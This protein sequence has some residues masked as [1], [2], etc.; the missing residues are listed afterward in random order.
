[1]FW[2]ARQIPQ[3]VS[4]P[5]RD[6]SRGAGGGCCWA[7]ASPCTWWWIEE[8]EMWGRE[9]CKHLQEQE[10]DDERCA[11]LRFA[12]SD[13]AGCMICRMMCIRERGWG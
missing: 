2:A 11:R 6:R 4:V 10:E 3:G 13:W 12:E 9:K 8:L 1:M 5:H 7:I